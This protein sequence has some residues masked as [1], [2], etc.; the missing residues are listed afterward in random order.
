MVVTS[1]KTEKL[2]KFLEENFNDT[3]LNSISQDLVHVSKMASEEQMQSRYAMI[4]QIVES[5]Q[6]GGNVSEFLR[7]VTHDEIKE[8]FRDESVF[9]ENVPDRQEVAQEKQEEI[10]K[11]LNSLDKYMKGSSMEQAIAVFSSMMEILGQVCV[12]KTEG[13]ILIKVNLKNFFMV[14]GDATAVE[15][16]LDQ[17][18]TLTFIPE[19]ITAIQMKFP[20]IPDND[21]VKGFFTS[22]MDQASDVIRFNELSGRLMLI[23]SKYFLEQLSEQGYDDHTM[24]KDFQERHTRLQLNLF[25]AINDLRD[26]EKLIN[27]HLENR[28]ILVDY[29]R[30]MREL[31]KIKIGL[32]KKVY[33]NKLLKALKSRSNEYHRERAAV[34]FDFNRLPTHQHN[35]RVRQNMVLKLQQELIEFLGSHYRNGFAVFQEELNEL[36]QEIESA[37]SHLEPSSPEFKELLAKKSK[38]QSKIEESRRRIDI[39]QCQQHLVAVQQILMNEAMERYKKRNQQYQEMDEHVKSQTQKTKIETPKPE[40]S[41]K[42]TAPNRMVRSKDK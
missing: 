9:G 31:I 22:V 2:L 17:E 7:N 25:N 40:V 30:Y 6:N 3:D 24:V 16:K 35:V 36:L 5:L 19:E 38:L 20:E 29:T 42:K 33:Q 37:S 21:P 10:Y 26:V 34:M 27:R 4:H 39:L 11:M 23:L 13:I 15:P 41:V 18:I 12:Q 28:T 1:D 8:S 14:S 32:T